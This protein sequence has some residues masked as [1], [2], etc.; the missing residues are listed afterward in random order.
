MDVENKLIELNDGKYV[1][2]VQAIKKDS[3]ET[4]AMAPYL[5]NNAIITKEAGQNFVTL[6]INEEEVVKGL[7]VKSSDNTFKNSI[8]NQVNQDE[9]VRYEI[10]HL[11]Q[12]QTILPARV[13]YK[14][15]YE[16]NII[17]GD[18]ELRLFIND[19]TIQ[20][21]EDMEF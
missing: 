15:N 21:V 17:E 4:S 8:N 6:V 5:A 16:G 2:E 14:I 12:I 18:E 19:D 20:N 11:E 10:F 9:N 3:T 7:Q 13:Q 1:V